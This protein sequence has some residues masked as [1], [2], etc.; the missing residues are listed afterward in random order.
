M[1]FIEVEEGFVIPNGFLP[2]LMGNIQELVQER[3]SI[4]NDEIKIRSMDLKYN[5]CYFHD[6]PT[7]FT[8]NIVDNTGRTLTI[9]YSL[10]VK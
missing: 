4:F 6:K 2:D 9:N 7:G 10:E 1:S 3:F 8:Y 5:N